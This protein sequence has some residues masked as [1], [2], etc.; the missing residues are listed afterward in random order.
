MMMMHMLH[1]LGVVKSMLILLKTMAD[2]EGS[3]ITIAIKSTKEKMEIKV[4]P[5]MNVSEVRTTN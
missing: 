3:D 5:S 2:K 1:I 4:S